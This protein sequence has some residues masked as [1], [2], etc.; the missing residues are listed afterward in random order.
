MNLNEI[1]IATDGYSK[2]QDD[3]STI[4]GNVWVVFKDLAHELVK[5]IH[6]PEVEVVVGCVA[7][8][9]HPK[10]LEALSEQPASVMVQ[11]ED[12]LRPDDDM[13]KADLRIAYKKIRGLYRWDC[14]PLLSSMSE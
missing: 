10:I 2:P 7:W 4:S 6:R 12:F 3:H 14:Q 1:H 9:T 13:N 11:K 5:L 8:L